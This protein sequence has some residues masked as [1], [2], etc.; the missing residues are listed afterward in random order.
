MAERI[1][2][3]GRIWRR[4]NDRLTGVRVLRFDVGAAV[5]IK[6]DDRAGFRDEIKRRVLCRRRA[7]KIRRRSARRFGPVRED[8]S[9]VLDR[10]K[11]IAVVHMVRRIGRIVR[12][13]L[14]FDNVAVINKRDRVCRDDLSVDVDLLRHGRWS[15]GLDAEG[16]RI[17]GCP[18]NPAG[19]DPALRGCRRLRRD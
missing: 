4:L 3:A 12:N 16:D 1:S 13:D 2:G 9:S 7:H 19:K 18:I 8:L 14:R 15:D 5:R 6:R 11:D 17:S 10:V